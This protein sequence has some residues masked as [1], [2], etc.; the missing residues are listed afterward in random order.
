MSKLIRHD[1]WILVAALVIHIL[2]LAF[3]IRSFY[4][5][6]YQPNPLFFS[7]LLGYHLV[8]PAW[9]IFIF[10][11]GNLILI[12]WL[13]KKWWK[14]GSLAALIYALSPWFIYLTIADSFYI[15]LTLLILSMIAFWS[16]Y[17]IS[18]KKMWLSG[19]VLSLVLLFY[20]SILMWPVIIIAVFLGFLFKVIPGKEA[21]RLIIL[22]VV[23]SLPVLVLT[24]FNRVA[25]VNTYHNG[26]GLLADPGV[27]NTINKFQGQSLQFGFGKV[28][29]L[30]ENKFEYGGTFLLYKLLA[31]FAIGNFFTAQGKLLNFSF[32][33]PIFLGWIIPGLWG[34]YLALKSAKTRKYLVISLTLFIPAFLSAKFIDLNRLVL[35]SP[36]IV[37]LISFGLIDLL[38]SIK[39]KKIRSFLAVMLILILLQ[40]LVT[41]FDMNSREFSRKE[42]Y[43]GISYFEIGKQ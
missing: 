23:I 42:H 6:F 30:A 26:V 7:E 3:A 14:Q 13:G 5:V 34:L 2:F 10:N 8:L 35:V 22:L 40:L 15:F 4:P 27:V 19:T 18:R 36:V 31:L 37:W 29:K 24:Y 16:K 1:G 33:A 9:T 21:G 32:T 38:K 28:S 20:S 39:S 11:F 41:L 25:L 17:Q 12:W 43:G